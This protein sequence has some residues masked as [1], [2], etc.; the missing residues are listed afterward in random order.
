MLISDFSAAV[1]GDLRSLGELGGPETAA[2]ADRLGVAMEAGLHRRLLDALNDV[3]Q[4]FNLHEG[5]PL[6]LTVEGDSVRLSRLVPANVDVATPPPGDYSARIALRLTDELKGDIE[7][8]A[9]DVGSS[10]NSW[11]VRTLE[12]SVRGHGAD[13]PPSGRN[14]LRGRGR[15]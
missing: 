5:V 13:A 15:A 9:T 2:L 8:L 11:I 12:R 10:V 1:R 6:T 3:L 14:E 7:H 4:E